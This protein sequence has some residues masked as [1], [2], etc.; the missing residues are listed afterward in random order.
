MSMLS[1]TH[2]STLI[3]NAG[4]SARTGWL[5]RVRALCACW[6]A[7][8]RG[9]R[10]LRTLSVAQLEDI[11]VTRYEADREANKPFWVE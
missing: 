3:H 7:R 8:A 11:G 9:R 6:E 4:A 5:R 10:V 1:N 2:Q